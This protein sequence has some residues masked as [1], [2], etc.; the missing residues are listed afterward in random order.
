MRRVSMH[1]EFVG[2]SKWSDVPLN[3]GKDQGRAGRS[4][5][6]AEMI[7][8]RILHLRPGTSTLNPFFFAIGLLYRRGFRFL[9]YFWPGVSSI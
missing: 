8:M 9:L 5:A 2:A 7:D 4:P 3:A 1:N 6:T